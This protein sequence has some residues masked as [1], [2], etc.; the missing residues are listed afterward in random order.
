MLGDLNDGGQIRD[1]DNDLFN[2][3]VLSSANSCPNYTE[4]ISDSSELGKLFSFSVTWL[5]AHTLEPDCLTSKLSFA[6]Y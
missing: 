6:F 5:Q 1:K 3:S 4:I 2:N